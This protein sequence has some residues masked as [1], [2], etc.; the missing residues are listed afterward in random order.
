MSNYKIHTKGLFIGQNQFYLPSCQSTNESLALYIT[1]Q[2]KKNS[3]TVFEGTLLWTNHQTKGKGQRG[4][5]WT[6]QENQNLTFSILL[7]PI[8]LSP[9]ESFWITIA[10]S[11]GVRDALEQVLKIDY[12]EI[13]DELKIKWTNDIFITD[14]EKDQKLGG[15]LIENQISSQAINQSIIGIGININQIFDKNNT[16]NRAISVKELTNKD[17]NKEDIL[18]EI[19]FFIEKR[20]LQLRAG[21]K[22]SLRADYLSHLF[23]YQ[24]WHYYKDK[25]K[26]QKITGQILGINPE[27][28]L[29][30][31]IAGQSGKITYFENKEIE[32]LY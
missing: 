14:N 25:I 13:A 17:W 22:D 29:A 24:E 31:E 4:N 16:E 7:N 23:R 30:L 1:E 21:K 6:T 15:I 3:N 32:F 18:T 19:L 12:P 11:L 26:N 10:V 20:Y 5:T 2:R 27:G 8:F 9:K 28:K